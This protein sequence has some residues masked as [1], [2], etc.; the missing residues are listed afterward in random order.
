M[1]YN[2]TLCGKLSTKNYNKLLGTA[3]TARLSS[4]VILDRLVDYLFQADGGDFCSILA[5]VKVPFDLPHDVCIKTTGL[6][7]IWFQKVSK[8]L[9][10]PPEQLVN[11]L[12]AYG[13]QKYGADLLAVVT[14][15]LRYLWLGGES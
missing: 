11:Q 4:E 13:F 6:N 12:L 9:G 10:V 14:D 7:K 2:E 15:P 1:F 8:E 3:N 5:S